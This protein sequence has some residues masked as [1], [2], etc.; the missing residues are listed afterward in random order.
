MIE[1]KSACKMQ[2]DLNVVLN[3]F[4]YCLEVRIML[5][6]DIKLECIMSFYDNKKESGCSFHMSRE[7]EWFKNNKVT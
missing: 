3:I 4:L 2:I 6:S 1:P 7:K 5:A